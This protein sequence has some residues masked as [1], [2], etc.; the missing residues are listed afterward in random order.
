MTD[1]SQS[2]SDA[3]Y[4]TSTAPE[5]SVQDAAVGHPQAGVSTQAR[6][7]GRGAVLERQLAHGR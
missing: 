2:P 1:P 5:L 4:T 7:R 3:R 6:E